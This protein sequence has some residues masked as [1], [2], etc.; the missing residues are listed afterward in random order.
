MVF[1]AAEIITLLLRSRFKTE[2][3]NIK[4]SS[5][6]TYNTSIVFMC[7]HFKVKQL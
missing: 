7:Q 3:L 1:N 6:N 2:Y 4:S 5:K